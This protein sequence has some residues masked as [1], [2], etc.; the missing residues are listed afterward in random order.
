VE[1][2][3]EQKVPVRLPVAD[4]TGE[5]LAGTR[6]QAALN[7]GNEAWYAVDEAVVAPDGTLSFTRLSERGNYLLRQ[8]NPHVK[9]AYLT[10][11]MTGPL[12]LPPLEGRVAPDFDMLPPPGA[13]GEPLQLSDLR[14]QVVVLD[15][16]A[17]WCGPCHE[18]LA[19]LEAMLARHPEWK[20]QVTAIALSVDDNL[21]ALQKY[22][23]R[24][25]WKHLQA[26]RVN[27]VDV[28]NEE[29][30]FEPL[31]VSVIPRTFV[32]DREGRVRAYY[33]PELYPL[34]QI[35]SELVK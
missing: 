28:K 31:A 2:P 19:N 3:E 34:E 5:P 16:W 10:A 21:P 30:V 23:D 33:H 24:K 22:L 12:L 8:E 7:L 25:Q 15:V 18:P 11:K 9:P 20:G 27:P 6:L 17:T 1:L 14:G 29:W 35:I 4:V 32:F 26:R 13:E